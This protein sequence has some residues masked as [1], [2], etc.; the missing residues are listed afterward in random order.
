[1]QSDQIIGSKTVTF[2]SLVAF[3][4]GQILPLVA[5]VFNASDVRDLLAHIT[6]VLGQ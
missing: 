2:T 4:A 3:T 6:H 1:M 5:L